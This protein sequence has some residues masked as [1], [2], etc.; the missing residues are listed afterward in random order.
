MN[1]INKYGII[2]RPVEVDDAE[3]ILSLRTD[4]NLNQF[5]SYTNPRIDD[6]INWI[7]NYK[8]RE[9]SGLEY[10]YVAEDNEGNKFGTIRLYDFDEKSFEIGSW[11][12][13]TNSPLGMAVKAHFIGF[14]TGFEVLKADYCRFEIRKKNLA[15]LRYMNDFKADKVGEDDLNYYFTLSKE[16]FYVR[17]NKISIFLKG[18]QTKKIH[19]TAEVQSINIG[20]GT[21]IWQYCVILKNAII[22]KNCNLNYNVFIENDVIIGDNV[23]I[24]S[25]V[26]LWDGLRIGNNVFISPNVTFTNDPTP[27]SKHY[28]KDFLTTN[29]NEGASIGANS[30]IIGGV[31]IGKYSMIG[32]G[33]V[34]TKNIPD[35]TLWYGNPAVFKGNICQ[36]GKKLD[37]LLNCTHCGKNYKKTNGIIQEIE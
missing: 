17:R 24:K 8:I 5:I 6:Q 21:Q 27:R 4:S 10:Y 37:E 20:E 30:S 26:Q 31:T 28:P 22:G 3:F 35:Y 25:G 13:R 14:E 15:V 18:N 19:Q 1:I 9:K 16:K 34:V 2:L 7:E 32:A 23:T 29:I 36:C 33:S 11:L 12:F